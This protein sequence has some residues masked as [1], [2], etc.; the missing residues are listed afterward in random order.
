MN[1]SMT[2]SESAP[3]GK[4]T[5][6]HTC[7]ISEVLNPA[8]AEEWAKAQINKYVTEDQEQTTLESKV[9][10]SKKPWKSRESRK[11]IETQDDGRPISEP[12]EE[13]AEE[14]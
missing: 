8:Q 11:K 9:G 5:T 6:K 13:P 1:L 7:S 3:S 12:E 10:K 4:Q 2:F 14:E